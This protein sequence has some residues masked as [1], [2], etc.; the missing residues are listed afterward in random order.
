M[1]DLSPQARALFD[2]ER[3]V[4]RPSEAEEARLRQAVIRRLGMSAFYAGTAG[5][6][7]SEIPAGAPATVATKSTLVIVAMVG[8]GALAVGA[9]VA[10][11][12][13]LRFAGLPL[14]AAA[15]QT[16]AQT[17]QTAA[18]AQPTN[19]QEGG[20]HEKSP[21]GL[22]VMDARQRGE[23]HEKSRPGTRVTDSSPRVTDAAMT[24]P[25]ASS[26]QEGRTAQ[27]DRSQPAAQ[28][29]PGEDIGVQVALLRKS[30]EALRQGRPD[31]ALARL[32][33]HE[34]RFPT[35]PLLQERQAGRVFALCAL[36]RAEQGRR[37]AAAFVTRFPR[38]PLEVRVRRACGDGSPSPAPSREK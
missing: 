13:S 25:A 33:E 9:I 2:A 16:A 23:T 12:T 31:V 1:T 11:V 26:P 18:P 10:V 4:D 6:A 7:E 27:L 32:R 38:S 15:Q 21:P 35:S 36:G 14:E 3:R 17:Q 37:E 34:A 8:L 29:E 19:H 22:G 24:Q 28:S 5:A 20:S 30:Q